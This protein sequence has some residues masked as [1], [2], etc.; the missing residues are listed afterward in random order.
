MYFGTVGNC[1]FTKEQRLNKEEQKA[2][3]TEG[4]WKENHKGKKQ[5]E[6]NWKDNTKERSRA[7]LI[8]S[9]R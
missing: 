2:Q 8:W 1:N 4:N 9:K 3:S 5:I 6:E 7:W